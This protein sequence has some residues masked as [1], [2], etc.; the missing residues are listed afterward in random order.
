LEKS[1]DNADAKKRKI[2][3]N[4]DDLDGES[5]AASNNSENTGG[6]FLISGFN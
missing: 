2:C 1:D 6:N 4:D 5:K 3:P